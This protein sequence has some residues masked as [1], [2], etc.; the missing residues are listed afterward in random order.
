MRRRK[1]LVPLLSPQEF[2][3]RT[4][5]TIQELLELN[6]IKLLCPQGGWNASGQG[7]MS[8]EYRSKLI[9]WGQRL[10]KRHEAGESWEELKEWAQNRWN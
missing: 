5:L 4:G 7:W 2:S 6:R 9:S 8:W 10:R 3:K 1:P